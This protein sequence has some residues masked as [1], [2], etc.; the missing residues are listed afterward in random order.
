MDDASLRR[1]ILILKQIVAARA[2]VARRKLR[3]VGRGVQ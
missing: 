3:A 1:W 2:E